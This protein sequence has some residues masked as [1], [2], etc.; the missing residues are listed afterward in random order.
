[1]KGPE[2]I[3]NGYDRYRGYR[4][5]LAKFAIPLDKRYIIKGGLSAEEG[6]A[7]IEAFLSQ[8]LEFDGLFGF[9][10]TSTLGA[11][12]MLQKKRYRIPED[13]SLCCMS[14]TTLCTLVHPMVTAVEQPVNKMA[15]LSCQLLLNQIADPDAARESVIIRG[16]IEERESTL[17]N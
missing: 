1:M 11:K 5:A 7:A 8:G 15:T 9:T 6:G 2:H 12:S 16:N 10:E 13:V 3:S 14:G 4:D 17:R